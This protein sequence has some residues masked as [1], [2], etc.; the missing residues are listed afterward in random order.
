TGQALRVHPHQG[1]I[2]AGESGRRAGRGLGPGRVGRP[3]RR[4]RTRLRGSRRLEREVL[5]AGPA[6]RVQLAPR[7]GAEVPVWGGEGDGGGGDDLGRGGQGLLRER[8]RDGVTIVTG[9]EWS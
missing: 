3:R 9:P 2:A 4:G 6:L 5:G 8:R 7:A 1:C